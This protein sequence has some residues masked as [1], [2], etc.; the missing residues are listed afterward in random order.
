MLV[1]QELLAYADP[2]QPPQIYYW[3]R[4]VKGSEAEV[5]FVIP[6]NGRVIP[7]EV[8]AGATGSLR[9]WRQFMQDKNCKMGVVTP[10]GS[11]SHGL[12]V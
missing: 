12:R 11:Y 1:G 5:D 7:I 2:E 10:Y 6:H 9:S 8:K 3:S 4:E